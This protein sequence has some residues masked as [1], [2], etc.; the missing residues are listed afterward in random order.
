M[1]FIV[2]GMCFHQYDK[3]D[4]HRSKCCA[5]K[6]I[7]SNLSYPPSTMHN[8]R[9]H[10]HHARFLLHALQKQVGCFNLR[11]VTMVADE[12]RYSGYDRFP[13]VWKNHN[14]PTTLRTSVK[15]SLQIHFKVLVR[16]FHVTR[17]GNHGCFQCIVV[18]RWT[19][20]LS[21]GFA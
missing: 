1:T 11:V 8:Y 6:R 15:D 9:H 4:H 3:Y 14:T 12:Q 20:K 21:L 16:N 10:C 17:W 7:Y 19:G 13:C 18:V 2:Q 5:V